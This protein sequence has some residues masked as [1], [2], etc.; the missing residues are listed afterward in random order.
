VVLTDIYAASELPIEGISGKA[1]SE[2]IKEINPC[3]K[4]DFVV[5]DSLIE[6]LLKILKPRDLVIMLGAGDITKISDGLA[7]EL[8]KKN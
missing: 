5:K 2:R 6:H 8:A 7:Q 4:V 1:V 3:K